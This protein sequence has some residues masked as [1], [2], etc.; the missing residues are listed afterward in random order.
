[1]LKQ[2]IVVRSDLKLPKGKLSA[3]VAHASLEAALK[4]DRRIV[5]AWR[6][7]GAKKV[8]LKVKDEKELLAVRKKADESK[9]KTALITDAG[10]TVVQPGTITCL[11]IGPEEEK[12]IDKITGNLKM[13]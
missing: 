13:V 2:V 3:Q 10:K 7:I 9:L 12:N 5:D 8:V 1:M 4:T 6:E 11:G